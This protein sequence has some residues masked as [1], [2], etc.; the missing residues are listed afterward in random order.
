MIYNN[1]NVSEFTYQFEDFLPS[2]E[3]PNPLNRVLNFLTAGPF[4]L[5]TDG[6]FE[7]EHFYEREKLLDFCFLNR[8]S[9]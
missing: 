8:K 9:A 2:L 6:S 7:K 3:N 1:L 5:E 4:V